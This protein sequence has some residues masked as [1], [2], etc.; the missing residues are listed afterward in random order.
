[1]IY[2]SCILVQAGNV[3]TGE[4]VKV[5]LEAGADIVK[6]GIGPGM[7]VTALLVMSLL[8]MDDLI[9]DDCHSS[10]WSWPLLQHS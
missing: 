6:V 10:S 2:L 3:V 8:C 9:H 4:M 5:L 7:A 1:M